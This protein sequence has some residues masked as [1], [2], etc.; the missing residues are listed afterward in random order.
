MEAVGETEMFAGERLKRKGF[1]RLPLI[2]ETGVAI[3]EKVRV[4]GVENDA[5]GRCGGV[6]IL[7]SE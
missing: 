7:R 3:R 1:L 5:L 6:L 4:L 2:A